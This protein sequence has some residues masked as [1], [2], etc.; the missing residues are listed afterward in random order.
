MNE[1][2]APAGSAAGAIAA[3]APAAGGAPGAPGAMPAGM[4]AGMQ[5]AIQ[6]MQ[7]MPPVSFYFPGG[8]TEY[9]TDIMILLNDY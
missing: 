9:F 4:Q 5:A 2:D 1:P 7:D 6:Q 3:A 8:I